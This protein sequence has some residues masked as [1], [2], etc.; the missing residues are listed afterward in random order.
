MSLIYQRQANEFHVTSFDPG[1]EHK[2]F[3][4]ECYGSRRLFS[5]SAQISEAKSQPEASE[6]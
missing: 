6:V 4:S 5:A 3:D 1:P 2:L